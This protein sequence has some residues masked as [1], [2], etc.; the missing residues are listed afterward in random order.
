M[1]GIEGDQISPPAARKFAKDD[2]DAAQ[3]DGIHLQS[4]K[5]RKK[6]PTEV[7]WKRT[8]A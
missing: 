7:R 4:A 6:M 3:K 2:A 1:G 8:W 5:P